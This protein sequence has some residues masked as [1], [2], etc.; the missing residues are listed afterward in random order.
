MVSRAPVLLALIAWAMGERGN[1]SGIPRLFNPGG[2]WAGRDPLG[3]RGGCGEVSRRD[4]PVIRFRGCPLTT[5]ISHLEAPLVCLSGLGYGPIPR[6][7][8]KLSPRLISDGVFLS[9][10]PM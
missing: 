6:F 10:A 1:P 4:R 2:L 5:V 7:V 8:T 9:G 3:Y